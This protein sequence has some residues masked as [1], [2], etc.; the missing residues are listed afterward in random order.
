MTRDDR[1][2]WF[3]AKKYGWGWTPCTAEGWAV[4]G[5]G[6]A[7]FTACIVLAIAFVD[8][9]AAFVIFLLLAMLVI[10]GIVY[11]GWRTGEKP[12]WRWGGG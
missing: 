9:T 3:A 4:V 10:G 6:I 7:L 12:G 11:V 8:T 1:R 2:I 5:V